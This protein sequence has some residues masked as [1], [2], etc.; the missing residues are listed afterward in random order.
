M[1]SSS[2]VVINDCNVNEFQ[3][4]RDAL[5]AYMPARTLYSL[6]MLSAYHL[7]FSQ[8]ACNFSVP[9]AGKTSIVYGAYVYLKNLPDDHPRKVDRLLIIGPLNAFGPWEMEFEEC[10]GTKPS[11]KRLTGKLQIDDK[12]QYLYDI[13]PA[14]LTL[15]SYASVMSLTDELGFFLRKHRVMVVLD[16][17]HKIKNTNGGIIAQSILSL[18]QDSKARVVLTGT[19]AP[20]GYEDLYNL[21]KFIWPTKDI[22]RFHIGQLK[23]MSRTPSVPRV[24]SLLNSISPFFIRIR[25]SDLG[26]PPAINNPPVM[27]EMGE[28]QRRIYD[29]IEKKYIFDI[30]SNKDQRFQNE[31]VRAR[32]IRLMQASTNP[33]LLRQPLSEFASVEGVDFGAVQDD[34][35]MISEI[36]RYSD[37]EIPAKYIAVKDVL[38]PIIAR[39]EKAIVWA[40]YIKNIELLQDYLRSQGIESRI[41]YG[42]TPVAGDGINED[43]EEYSNTRE[44]IVKEFHRADCPYNVIIANPF[45]VAESISLHKAC[46][47]AIYLERSFNAAHFMQSKDRIHRYGLG[48]DV[49]TNYYYLL[50]ADSVDLTIHERLAEKERRLLDIIESMPIPL[51]D[52]T[53][54][55]GG[56]DD[57]KAV[58][59]DYA[60]RTK[61]K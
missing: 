59:R 54:E 61:A 30:A 10:F 17:A 22:I 19:P 57:I 11:A 51:F 16:E 2:K 7:A 6:Q 46:H 39:G 34:T 1:F 8:N 44:A 25:K 38:Q 36:L 42:A 60:R 21:F 28:S 53:L 43:D 26:I 50:S 45:A 37:A 55:D 48:E 18:A 13:N 3:S 56:D 15:I 33:A 35:A 58:L 9:G 47:N 5:E 52:N 32:L 27:V 29:F 49:I 40:C 12:K 24:D 14:E 20:N 23:D 4:F 31:L 41:L